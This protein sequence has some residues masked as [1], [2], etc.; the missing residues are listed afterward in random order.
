MAAMTVYGKKNL[1]CLHN[2][3]ADRAQIAGGAT[4]GQALSDWYLNTDG[5]G[6]TGLWQEGSCLI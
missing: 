6:I 3:A 1:L 5:P 4:F 2:C